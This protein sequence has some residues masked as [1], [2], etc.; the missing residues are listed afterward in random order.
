MTKNYDTLIIG[1][2]GAGL[3]A[4]AQYVEALRVGA[5][6]PLKRTSMN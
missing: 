6:S 3:K 1:A 4:A 2:G 5:T